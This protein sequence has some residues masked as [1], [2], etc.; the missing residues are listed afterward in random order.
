MKIAYI[1]T[2]MGVGG[3]EIITIDI[4]NRM[5]DKGN[6]VLILYLTG[7]NLNQHRI[8]KGITIVGLNMQ[9]NPFSLIKSLFRAKKILKRFNPDIV[10]SNMYHANIFSRILRIFYRFKHLICSEHNCKIGVGIRQRI[11]LLVYQI[12]RTLSDFDTNVSQEAVALFLKYKSFNK[13]KSSCMYN[14]VD[15]KNFYPNNKARKEIREIY[16]IADNEFIFLNVGRLTLAK[17]QKNLIEAFSLVSKEQKNI[18]LIIVGK[19]ELEQELK[20][21]VVQKNVSNLVIFAG[22]IKNVQDYYN[23]SDVFILSSAWE[24]FAIVIAEAMACAL[25]I[26]TTDAGGTREVLNNKQFIVQIR[27]SLALCSKMKYMC[28]LTNEERKQI[29]SKNLNRSKLFNID[30]I[31]NKWLNIYEALKNNS[32]IMDYR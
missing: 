19:G 22:N 11:C 30:S 21:F 20:N 1:I 15:L 17:D 9:K 24:G 12:T 4:A 5:L 26:I 2:S 27:N 14:G 13:S 18:R 28:S 3:A 23:A 16:N 7:Q 6:G 10:H 8:N 25:P 31:T 29:G 32:N